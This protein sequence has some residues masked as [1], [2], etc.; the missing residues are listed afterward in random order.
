M[1]SRIALNQVAGTSC[2][3]HNQE[4]L[5]LQM[6]K[7]LSKKCLYMKDDH[8]KTKFYIA[9]QCGQIIYVSFGI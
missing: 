6:F 4:I 1:C 5:S 3:Q 7:K 9:I 2:K 8:I